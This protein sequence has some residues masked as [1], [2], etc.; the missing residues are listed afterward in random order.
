MP[1]QTGDDGVHWFAA[2]DVAALAAELANEPRMQRRLR[3]AV[4]APGAK[5]AGRP[6]ARSA[7]EVAALVFERLEQRQSLAEIVIGVR[8][9]PERVRELHEQWSQGLIEHGL[10]KD[11]PYG[12]RDREFAHIAPAALAARLAELPEGLIRISVGRYRGEWSVSDPDGD[13]SDFAQI[14]ELG[15]FVVSGPCETTEVTRRFGGGD[16]RIT[17]CRV[18]PTTFLW[19]VISRGVRAPK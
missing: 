14:V 5:G 4:G 19:E 8:V 18:E 2:A 15:G 17:T 1:A 7:D 6:A 12:P 16:Y 11:A 13:V 9:A 10:A 3:N